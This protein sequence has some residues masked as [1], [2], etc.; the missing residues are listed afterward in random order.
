[1]GFHPVGQAG[2]ELVTSDCDKLPCGEEK[3]AMQLH[4]VLSTLFPHGSQEG[5]EN[6]AQRGTWT[7]GSQRAQQQM[8][9]GHSSKFIFCSKNKKSIYLDVETAK[10]RK[11]STISPHLTSLSQEG[12][13]GVHNKQLQLACSVSRTVYLSS[14]LESVL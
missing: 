9:S 11:N 13:S 4:Q 1:M 7:R 5:T 3:E 12:R 14:F 6:G 10:A 2:L 8:A